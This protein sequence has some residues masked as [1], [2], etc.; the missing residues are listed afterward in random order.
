MAAGNTVGWY[1]MAKKTAN[2]FFANIGLGRTRRN[3]LTK[4]QTDERQRNFQQ[5]GNRKN[6]STGFPVEDSIATDYLIAP[7]SAADLNFDRGIVSPIFG[8]DA[9]NFDTIELQHFGDYE[10]LIPVGKRQPGVGHNF[11]PS[12]LTT[13]TYCDFCGEFCW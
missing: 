7:A 2:D 13:V 9:Q 11:R 12:S 10:Q 4:S 5:N 1:T 6:Y 3:S 8:E